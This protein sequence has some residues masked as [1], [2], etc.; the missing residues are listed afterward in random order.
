MKYALEQA[1]TR[2]WLGQCIKPGVGVRKTE[3]EGESESEREEIELG[4]E[5]WEALPRHGHSSTARRWG[6]GRGGGAARFG[7]AVAVAG[8]DAPCTL[9]RA[10][11][12]WAAGPALGGLRW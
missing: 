2:S 11:R 7:A 10:A 3:G 1:F 4:E 5:S 9:C 6:V 8:P 12:G